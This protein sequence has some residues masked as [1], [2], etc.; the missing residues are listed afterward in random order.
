LAAKRVELIKQFQSYK[1]DIGYNSSINIF[2]DQTRDKTGYRIG[3]DGCKAGWFYFATLG[4][5]YEF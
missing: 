4:E 3:V 2:D 1:P 5:K